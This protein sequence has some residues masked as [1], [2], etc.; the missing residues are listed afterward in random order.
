MTLLTLFT[1]FQAPISNSMIVSSVPAPQSSMPITHNLVTH[2][3][4][5]V[6]IHTTTSPYPLQLS[7]VHVPV[8][9]PGSTSNINVPVQLTGATT[10]VPLQIT[11]VSLPIQVSGTTS[12][13]VQ[14]PA[15]DTINV[16]LQ[17]PANGQNIQLTGPG[18]PSM[19]ILQNT[20]Q[21]L[22]SSIFHVHMGS[23]Q[24]P[25]HI[26]GTELSVSTSSQLLPDSSVQV[27]MSNPQVQVGSNTNVVQIPN[28]SNNS[29]QLTLPSSGSAGTVQLRG[30]GR[31][32]VVYIQ[33]PTGLKPVTSTEVISQAST[34]GN[35][36]QII[37]RR[38]V[39]IISLLNLLNCY[40]VTSPQ[41]MSLRVCGC[42]LLFT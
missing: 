23:N 31:S 15:G 27:K 41:F 14:L 26:D 19:P 13:P 2:S 38:P 7:T 32:H 42:I 1:A 21:P 5:P 24:R 39:S 11:P 33:T 22:H 4:A 37:V 12:V 35:P 28:T 16:P 10:S 18:L 29:I 9:I 30:A 34:S 36:P 20:S 25:T 6:K 3:I 17:I 40:C 8:Q